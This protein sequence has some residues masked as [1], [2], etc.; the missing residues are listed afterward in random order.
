M[1]NALIT[2][3]KLEIH[4]F[5]SSELKFPKIEIFLKTVGFCTERVKG[6]QETLYIQILS[7]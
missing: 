4:D 3:F 1:K 6:D 2:F 7:I 5:S